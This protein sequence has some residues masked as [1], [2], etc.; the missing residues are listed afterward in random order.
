MQNYVFMIGYIENIDI[1]DYANQE[2][3]GKVT[4][5]VNNDFFN[6]HTNG[7]IAKN[8][9]LVCNKND[10]IGIKGHLD[11][12]KGKIIINVERVSFLKSN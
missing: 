8:I 3:R 2:T 12:E 10:L 1:K 5:K 4:L 11:I 6:I 9:R 7:E